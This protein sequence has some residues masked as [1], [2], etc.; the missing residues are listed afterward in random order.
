MTEQLTDTERARLDRELRAR[1]R[2]MEAEARRVAN[3]LREGMRKSM[4]AL[5][6]G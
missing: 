3:Q 5:L 6:G 1:Q 4:K 2:A